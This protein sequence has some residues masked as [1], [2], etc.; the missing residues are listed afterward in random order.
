MN[1]FFFSPWKENEYQILQTFCFHFKKR[2]LV[3]IYK[4]DTL[5]GC[6]FTFICIFSMIILFSFM[7]TYGMFLGWQCRIVSLTAKF[8]RYLNTVFFSINVANFIKTSSTHGIF[9]TKKVFEKQNLWWMSKLAFK[10][11]NFDMPELFQIL[12]IYHFSDWV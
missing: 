7:L 2:C 12:Q 9:Q 1:W 8:S 10:E 3:N 11:F 4:M 6:I 5:A